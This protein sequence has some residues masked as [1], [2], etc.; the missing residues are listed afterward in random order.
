[1][2][3]LTWLGS[4]FALAVGIGLGVW[5]MRR[6]GPN[7]AEI[8]RTEKSIELLAERNEIGRQQVGQLMQI[9]LALKSLAK[10][11]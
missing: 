8:E 3:I 5:M 2:V 1:M 6:V 10:G 9:E 4:G 11:Q 7:R